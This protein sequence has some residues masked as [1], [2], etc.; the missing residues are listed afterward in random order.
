MHVHKNKAK[1]LTHE[2]SKHLDS[3]NENP[4]IKYR[5]VNIKFSRDTLMFLNKEDQYIFYKTEKDFRA[6]FDEKSYLL[7]TNWNFVD[8]DEDSV[9]FDITAQPF[10]KQ[11]NSN[12][13]KSFIFNDASLAKDDIESIELWSYSRNQEKK[14]VR[15]NIFLGILSILTLILVGE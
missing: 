8:I 1:I 7:F 11:K 3:L 15:G 5:I 14:A 9:I 2:F 10:H 12:V 6:E 13:H 4:D